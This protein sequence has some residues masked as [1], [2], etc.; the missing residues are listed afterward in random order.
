MRT[1]A[2]LRRAMTEETE[3]LVPQVTLETVRATARRR[4]VR[5][6]GAGAAVMVLAM[7]ASVF[8]A[9]TRPDGLTGGPDPSPVPSQLL[10]T[11]EPAPDPSA[12]PLPGPPDASQLPPGSIRVD[13]SA[14]PKGDII[15][16]HVLVNAS[17][18]LVV[19]FTDGPGGPQMPQMLSGL[20]SRITGAFRTLGATGAPGP[21]GSPSFGYLSQVDSHNGRVIDYGLYVGPVS[22]IVADAQGARVPAQLAHWSVDPKFVVFWVDRHGIPIPADSNNPTTTGP[23]QPLFTALDNAG[24]VLATSAGKW[25]ARTDSSYRDS[26]P[27]IGDEIRTGAI[28]ADGTELVLRFTGDDRYWP[29]LSSGDRPLCSFARPPVANGFG[30]GWNELPI[31]NEFEGRSGTA[32]LVSVYVGPA[33]RVVVTASG[34]VRTGS[35]QWSVYPEVFVFWAA[36]V[37]VAN[38]PSIQVVAYDKQ[39]RVLGRLGTGR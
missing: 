34:G 38:G 7:F 36:D 27:Q 21:S 15:N 25:A 23:T 5:Y 33:D 17:E 26:R 16:T 12:S 35:A 24:K 22:R 9:V 39:G 37:T 2:D 13:P 11:T 30:P 32:I 10:P 1:V 14:A 19:Y 8:V 6:T 28:R 3:D 20:H 31:W 4:T 18:E 29:W